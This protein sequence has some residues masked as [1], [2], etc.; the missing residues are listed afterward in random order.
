[1]NQP[2]IKHTPKYEMKIHTRIDTFKHI[3]AL[4]V[5]KYVFYLKQLNRT[6]KSFWS[7]NNRINILSEIHH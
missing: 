2:F 5:F 4:L 6:G 1:M 3:R 7:I